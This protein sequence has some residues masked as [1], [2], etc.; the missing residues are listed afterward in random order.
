MTSLP[1]GSRIEE[2]LHTELARRDGRLALLEIG[3]G[4]FS[5]H[6]ELVG[7]LEFCGCRH[8]RCF[9]MTIESDSD[10]DTDKTTGS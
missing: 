9:V 4:L 6:E 10:R 3:I 2:L 5:I 1:S 8:D 7:G